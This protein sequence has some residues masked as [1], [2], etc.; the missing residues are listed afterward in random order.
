MNRLPSHV[1]NNGTHLE[2]LLGVKPDYKSLRT[3]GCSYWPNLRP[4]NQRKLQ[5]RSTRC[6]SLGYSPLHNGFKCLEVSTGRVYISRDV[7]FNESVFPFEQLHPNAGALLQKE[8]LLL[9]DHGGASLSDQ[10]VTNV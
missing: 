9:P 3:F 10:H 7:V 6:V 1:I 8:L 4:F 5:F 2:R